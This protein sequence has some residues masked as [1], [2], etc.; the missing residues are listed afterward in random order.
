MLTLILFRSW[1]E[2]KS[3]AVDSWLHVAEPELQSRFLPALRQCCHIS[4]T[5]TFSVP[6]VRKPLH[7]P[8]LT[9]T[10]QR[11][12]REGNPSPSCLRNT[13][14]DDSW[15]LQP[16]SSTV[17]SSEDNLEHRFLVRVR[18]SRKAVWVTKFHRHREVGQNYPPNG[19]VSSRPTVDVHWPHTPRRD[20]PKSLLCFW[21][22]NL[23]LYLAVKMRSSA[24]T[25]SSE[26]QSDLC[27]DPYGNKHAS[28]LLK[29]TPSAP[30]RK[31]EF[32]HAI[33]LG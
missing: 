31:L 28:R 21:V 20:S 5:S 18:D 4:S 6:N 26:E 3:S 22:I 1:V 32:T 23:G 19:H 13:L 33:R 17:S 24:L 16:T 15:V 27:T 29:K 11:L 9:G 30:E 14:A 8:F 7:I 10:H 2:R 12:Q 25:H